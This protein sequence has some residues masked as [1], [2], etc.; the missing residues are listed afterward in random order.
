[1]LHWTEGARGRGVLCSCDIATVTMDRIFFTFMRS[2]PNPIPLSVKGVSANGAAPEPF[3]FAAIS[4]HFFDRVLPAGGKS[5]L[6]AS[7]R[8]YADAVN[9]AYD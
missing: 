2:Y 1:M 5:I 4:G 7:M 6:Q 8:R 3:A 9:G